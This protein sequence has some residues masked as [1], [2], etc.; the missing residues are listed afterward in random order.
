MSRIHLTVAL[1]GVLAFAPFT[2]AAVVG[3]DTFDVGA[4]PSRDDDGDDPDDFQFWKVEGVNSLS[5][6]DD[7]AGIGSGNALFINQSAGNHRFVAPFPTQTLAKAGDALS[8]SFDYRL[9]Q[10]ASTQTFTPYFG[11]YHDGGTPMTADGQSGNDDDDAGYA[12]RTSVGTQTVVRLGAEVNADSWIVAGSDDQSLQDDTFPGLVQGEVRNYAL[13]ITRTVD[14]VQLDL[15]VTDLT[16][17]PTD[18]YSLTHTFIAV[19]GDPI[20]TSF[21]EFALRTR[22]NNAAIDNLNITFV[23]EPASLVLL[24]LSGAAVIRRRRNYRCST[25]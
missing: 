3:L 4:S 24:G 16:T 18:D 13:T 21:N 25:R 12:A 7:P 17:G 5:V 23:P 8:V 2:I 19:D 11:L 15:V 1:L 22:D 10:A 6:A 14:G 20:L 9:T